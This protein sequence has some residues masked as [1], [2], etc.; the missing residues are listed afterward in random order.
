MSK[1]E[2]IPPKCEVIIVSTS[3]CI[4]TGSVDETFGDGLPGLDRDTD[5][6][7]WDD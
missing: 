6:L 7:E 5:S 2:F 1:L 4:L 3:G